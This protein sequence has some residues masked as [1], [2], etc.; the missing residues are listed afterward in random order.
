[1]TLRLGFHPEAAAELD[2]AIGW[3][4]QGGQG[5]GARFRAD[6]DATVDRLFMWP[7]SGQVIEV[8]GTEQAF[9]QA[10]IPDSDYRI[11]YYLAGG[12]VKVVAVAHQRRRPRYWAARAREMD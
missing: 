11:V 6:F 8:Q 12:V 5:R 10:K 9:R 2:H 3:Y 4:D 7:E 1:M